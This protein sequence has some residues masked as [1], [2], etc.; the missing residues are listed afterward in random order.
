MD[1][2]Q[3]AVTPFLTLSKSKVAAGR[4]LDKKENRHIS[5]AFEIS[6]PN[7]VC[8]YLRTF[9]NVRDVILELKQNP[10][11][12][13]AAISKKRKIAI[14]LPPFEVLSPNLA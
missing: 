14:T 8:R 2:P 6:S 7:F 9:R 10:R 1:S 12:P 5:A 3:R 4:H 11:W 13:P